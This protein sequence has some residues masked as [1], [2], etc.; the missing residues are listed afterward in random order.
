M[1]L[2]QDA[3]GLQLAGTLTVERKRLTDDLVMLDSSSNSLNE[4]R[5]WWILSSF[6]VVIV[7][8]SVCPTLCDPVDC[9]TPGFPVLHHLPEFAQTHIH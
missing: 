7:N 6:A 9:S 4:L 3:S 8:C 2:D 1:F 5:M